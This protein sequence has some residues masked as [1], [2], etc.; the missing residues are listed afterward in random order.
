MGWQDVPASSQ[1][2]AAATE[3]GAATCRQQDHAATGQGRG[4]SRRWRRAAAARPAP[5]EQP[6]GGRKPRAGARDE[7]ERQVRWMIHSP[8]LSSS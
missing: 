8:L 1:G 3:T 7:D 6:A 2:M 5:G 4:R